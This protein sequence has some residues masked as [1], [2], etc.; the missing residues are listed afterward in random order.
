[1]KTML[2]KT[3]SG[4]LLEIDYYPAWDSGKAIPSK[5]PKKKR[6]TEEQIRYNKKQAVKKIVRLVNANFDDTDIIM[7]PTYIQEA[8]PESEE[9]A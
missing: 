5:C 8:A 2:K 6:S 9:E 1:M 7:H 4:K 3:K